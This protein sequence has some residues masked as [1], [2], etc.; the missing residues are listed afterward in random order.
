MATNT[1]VFSGPGG[2]RSQAAT[3][4][5]AQG[6][7]AAEDESNHGLPDT[8]AGDKDP[9]VGWI[10]IQGED[11]DIDAALGA[12]SDL[13]WVLRS[14]YGAPIVTSPL[15][16]DADTAHEELIRSLVRDEMAKA[17]AR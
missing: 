8:V 2:F 5:E 14:H 7:T 13:N 6:F 17:Q 16:V 1:A 4:L 15:L 3:A 11:V 12:V 10:T 9:T